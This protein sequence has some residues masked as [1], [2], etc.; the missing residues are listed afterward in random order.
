ME[1]VNF[2]NEIEDEIEKFNNFQTIF[3]KAYCYEKNTLYLFT[4]TFSEKYKSLPLFFAPEY[5]REKKIAEI[6][7]EKN[8]L[9]FSGSGGTGKTYTM[10]KLIQYFTYANIS[11]FATAST[12][13]A[14][15]NLRTDEVD[16]ARYMT[17]HRWAGIGCPPPKSARNIKYLIIDEISMVG[18]EMWKKIIARCCGIDL[19]TSGDFDQLQPVRDLRVDKT[20]LWNPYQIIFSE[21]RRFTLEYFT[22]LRE[23]IIPAKTLEATNKIIHTLQKISITEALDRK[24]TILSCLK[25]EAEKINKIELEK[26]PPGKVFI[27][28]DNAPEN[29]LQIFHREITFPEQIDLREGA[30]VILR[31]NIDIG[32]GLTNGSLGIVITVSPLFV[33]FSGCSIE[34]TPEKQ[35]VIISKKKYWREQ[36]PLIL[37][38]A[39]TVHQAQ[40]LTLSNVAFS[41]QGLFEPSQLY[42]AMSRVSKLDSFKVAF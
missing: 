32:R 2:C 39:L 24:F 14:V 34:I 13:T 26:L 12:G 22:Y 1:I 23:K 17:V 41:V 25:R 20:I 38:W 11:F 10:V 33:K 21:P 7:A 35:S 15:S 5:R 3:G 29:S 40:G 30:H 28:I 31:K 16:P 42:V 6:A 37:G 36:V 4:E 27:A 9:H 18:E 19:I 8:H